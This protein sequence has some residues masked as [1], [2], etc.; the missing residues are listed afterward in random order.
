MSESG[1]QD[2]TKPVVKETGRSPSIQVVEKGWQHRPPGLTVASTGLNTHRVLA[3]Q[4]YTRAFI[5]KPFRASG[6]EETHDTASHT[7][8]AQQH[9]EFRIPE[10]SSAWTPLRS[11]LSGARAPPAVGE[12]EPQP[13]R[14]ARRD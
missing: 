3:A 11:A 9:P 4:T 6:A 1:S 2:P 14:P 7:K 8:C 12:P 5:C 10:T 13:V